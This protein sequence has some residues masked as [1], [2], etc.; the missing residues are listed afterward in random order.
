MNDTRAETLVNLITMLEKETGED[1]SAEE[2]L[3]RIIEELHTLRAETPMI[4]SMNF[5]HGAVELTIEGARETVLDYVTFKEGNLDTGERV[6]VAGKK[7]SQMQK[8]AEAQ[9]ETLREALT[10]TCL[11]LDDAIETFTPDDQ[12][13]TARRFLANGRAALAS[14]T[15]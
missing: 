5:E 1:E 3:S 10:G 4:K 7:P 8:E 12:T 2:T 15:K 11:A 6:T 14:L 13:T 9:V